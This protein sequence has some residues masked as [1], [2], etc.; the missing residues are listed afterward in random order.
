[1]KAFNYTGKTQDPDLNSFIKW[2]KQYNIFQESN[3]KVYDYVCNLI[4]ERLDS[5]GLDYEIVRPD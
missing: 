1:M 3:S 2:A 4:K 5:E